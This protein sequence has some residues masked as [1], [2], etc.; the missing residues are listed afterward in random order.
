MSKTKE[1][2]ESRKKAIESQLKEYNDLKNELAEVDKAL[3]ALA[4]PKCDS[5][6]SGCFICR[7]GPDYR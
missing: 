7:N 5:R 6:C 3:A 1:Y 2:L 4:S